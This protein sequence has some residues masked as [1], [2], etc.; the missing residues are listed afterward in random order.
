M[1][2]QIYEV[3]GTCTINVVKR[4]KAKDE[5][6]ALKKASELF[7]GLYTE[8]NGNSVFVR[9]EG[10]EISEDGGYVEWNNAY[11]T[12]DDDYDRSDDYDDDEEE[13]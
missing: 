11:V 8:W 1:A 4:V 5:Y 13:D 9:G 6:D 10:E 12:D 7:D 2:K 3:V